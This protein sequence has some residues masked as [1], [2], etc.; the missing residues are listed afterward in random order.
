MLQ[1]EQLTWNNHKR[2]RHQ[3]F[4]SNK[5][6]NQTE[7]QLWVSNL[8]KKEQN[9]HQRI[10]KEF[11]KTMKMKRDRWREKNDKRVEW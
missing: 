6:L 7:R 9:A 8:V 1:S 5:E 11:N 3:K 10:E 2:E 4:L